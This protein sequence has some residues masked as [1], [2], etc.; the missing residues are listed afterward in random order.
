MRALNRSIAAPCSRNRLASSPCAM[1]WRRE[2]SVMAR[3]SNPIAAQPPPSPRS[4][5]ARRWRSCARAGR[6]AGRPARRASAA[7]SPAPR[8]SRHGPRA[9][10]AGSTAA[11]APQTDSSVSPAMRVSPRKTPYSL[12]F[13][14]RSWARRRN[15]T[16]CAFDPVKYCNAEPKLSE[17]AGAG[18]PAGRRAAA[19]W[20]A[21]RRWTAL[22]RL[23]RSR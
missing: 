6:R 16:L 1:P 11:R 19:R 21:C 23:R 5:C 17:R 4:C 20:R 8:R 10:P 14:P 18:R 22:P 9:A 7:G 3:Y 12:T 2:C 15:A 13:R